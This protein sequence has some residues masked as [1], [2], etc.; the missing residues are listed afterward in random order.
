V[1]N[2]YGPLPSS[3]LLR[4]YGYLT[5]EHERYDVAELPWSLVQDA[6]SAELGMSHADLVKVQEKL[7]EEEELEE[8]F[9]IERDSGDPDEEGHIMQQAKLRDVSPELEEQVKVFLKALKK[10]RPDAVPEKRKHQD[11]YG[12]IAA[13]ALTAKLAQYPTSIEEDG[14][15]LREGEVEKRRRMAIEMRRGEKRLLQEALAL[16]KGGDTGERAGKRA[17]RE[18]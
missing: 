10:S 3:E 4:R 12:S 17:K 9:I 8:Y 2:Y 11:I 16:V 13:R 14:A 5:P 18:E 6:L 7:E 1:L 15:L